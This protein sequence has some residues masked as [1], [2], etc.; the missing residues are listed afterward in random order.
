MS[1]CIVGC[2]LPH[3]L[4]VQLKV[5]GSLVPFALKGRN[6]ARIIGGYGLTQGVPRDAM[7]DWLDEHKDMPAVRNKFIFMHSDMASARAHARENEKHTTGLE[8]ID[9]M[10]SKRV[11]HS[12]SPEDAKKLTQQRAENPDRNRQIVE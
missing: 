6:A 1:T 8:P 7:A 9:P 11:G 10:D 3:G 4:N 2:K 12:I 5:S